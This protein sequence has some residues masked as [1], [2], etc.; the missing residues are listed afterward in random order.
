MVDDHQEEQEKDEQEAR[1][2]SPEQE[3]ERRP[4]TTAAMEARTKSPGALS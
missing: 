4:A 2:K 1:A 3:D